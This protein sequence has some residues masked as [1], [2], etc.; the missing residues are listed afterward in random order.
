MLNRP[1]SVPDQRATA[2]RQELNAF[3]DHLDSQVTAM[4]N[5]VGDSKIR[6]QLGMLV[7]EPNDALPKRTHH[8][9]V[10]KIHTVVDGIYRG[11]AHDADQRDTLLGATVAVHEYYDIVD[12]FI[13][14][15]VSGGNELEVYVTN[16]LLQPLIVSQLASL[17]ADVVET[18]A[19]GA[20]Q[21]TSS[22]VEELSGEPDVAAYLN[23]ID[24]Q[25]HL[26]GTL[27]RIA[28]VA[29]DGEDPAVAAAD[30]AGRAFFRYEQVLRDCRQFHDDEDADPWNAFALMSTDD[31][32]EYVSGEA[33]AFETAISSL[34]VPDE[35]LLTTL[36]ATDLDEFLKE[37][38]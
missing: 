12:D 24:Q 30:R 19:D 25:A 13:D 26:W 31:W 16:E 18:W 38:S 34:P 35:R 9:P 3:G 11:I 23:L 10:G 20:V 33:E 2:A 29:A 15:D 37:V 1:L 5:D 27:T 7:F 14:G 21:T 36:V 17:G 8:Q 4:L 6:Y 22:F 28:A 32:F